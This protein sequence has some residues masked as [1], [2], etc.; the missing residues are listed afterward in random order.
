[1]QHLYQKNTTATVMQWAGIIIIVL[2]VLFGILFYP[3]IP[4]GVIGGLLLMG[5]GEAIGLLQGIYNRLNPDFDAEV[6]TNDP[7]K[8][9]VAGIYKKLGKKLLS[10]EETKLRFHY[11]VKM[12]DG[13]KEVVNIAYFEPRFMTVDEAIEQ[14]I[15]D[16]LSINEA[17]EKGIISDDE[18]VDNA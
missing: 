18:K 6:D 4:I 5:L 7:Q 8:N 16:I 12:V 10:I 3:L 13:K 15:V 2:S 14:G 17:V 1:M 9:A 11:L